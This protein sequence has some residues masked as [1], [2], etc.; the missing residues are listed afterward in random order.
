MTAI[1]FVVRLAV[2]VAATYGLWAIQFAQPV[3]AE[4]VSISI[5]TALGYGGAAG[6]LAPTAV[7]ASLAFN[8]ALAALPTLLL[9]AVIGVG[10]TLL[11]NSMRQHTQTPVQDPGQRLVNLRQTVQDRF[12]GVGEMRI[13]G[14]V[15]FWKAKD[16]KRY[17]ALAM[18]TG[19]ISGFESFFL[20]ETEVTLDGSGYV[21]QAAMIS[22]GQSMVQVEAFV[23]A[24]GQ[25][26][27]ALLEGNFEEWGTERTFA[28]IAGL[29]VSFQNPDPNDFPRVYPNGRERIVTALARLA[30]VY[31]PRD[32]AQDPDDSSTWL[33]SQN[34]ALCIAYW[35]TDPDGL[36]AEVDWD[37][38]A[39]EADVAD[40]VV[41]DRNG[42]P[43]P[44]WR[45]SGTW[46]LNQP[47]ETVRGAL[48]IACDAFFYDRNDGKVGFKLGRWFEPAYTIR[49]EHVL[50][51]R[52]IEGQDGTEQFN[53]MSV[54]YTE[55]G[56]GYRAFQTA[57]YVVADGKPYREDS[58]AALYIPNHNQ[59]VRVAK[60]VLRSIR[61]PYSLQLTLKLY[62]LVLQNQRFF[63][64]EDP[65]MDISDTFEMGTWAFSED[66][67]TISVSA[68]SVTQEDLAFNAATEEPLPS[69]IDDVAVTDEVAD[70][71]NVLA[72]S[73][74][75][76]QLSVTFD[77]P[78]RSSLLVR[79]RFREVGATDW[80]EV[81][82]P[83]GQTY[84]TVN[85]LP[86]EAD[87]QAQIQFRTAVGVGSNWVATT[88]AAVT[89]T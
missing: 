25:A 12:K 69:Q 47:R 37:E 67:L 61:A 75:V 1:A 20:D 52:L 74:A 13:G 3:Q 70:P 59:G 63:R 68:K 7:L 19:E 34:A 60:R 89:I 4:P 9:N 42:N 5:L 8:A 84:Y 71:E 73:P 65:D 82:V 28:G 17:V 27:P 83:S 62:G 6:L 31:D 55:P 50:S 64:Y 22:N 57:P 54:Q 30:K 32:P 16:G 38:V 36:N 40:I 14:A 72:S 79:M 45:V 29:V 48:A 18:N 2:H 85:G 33:F 11:A 77:P 23:G 26:A 76:G 58:F 39:D 43:Q 66:G 21:E 44:K 35:V 10:L 87:Y 81:G 88:P 78:S 41:T 51:V 24:P 53:A 86:S 56:A 46:S 80:N 15:A 49:P